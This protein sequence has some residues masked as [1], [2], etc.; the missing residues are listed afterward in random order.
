[1]NEM[2]KLGVKALKCF[3]FEDFEDKCSLM[4]HICN[5]HL[6]IIIKLRTLSGKWVILSAS[7]GVI[8]CIITCKE[9][10]N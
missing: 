8:T 6:V 10:R 5:D 4:R 1:M 3:L 9:T 2:V 7:L